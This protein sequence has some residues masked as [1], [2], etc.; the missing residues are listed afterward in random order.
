M[1]AAV[2]VLLVYG[3]SPSGHAA[4]A[5]SLEE[6]FRAEGALVSKVEVSEGHHPRAGRTVAR[7][8]HALLRAFPGLYGA[9]YGSTSARKALRGIRSAYLSA[10]GANRLIAGV[11]REA[12]DLIVCPQAAVAAVFA[13]A[14]ARG[15]LDVPVV[16]VLTDYAAHPFWADPAADFVI[17]PSQDVA[18]LLERL[19]VP[20]DR[21]SVHGI[22]IHP[23]FSSLP[24]RGEA[25]KSLALPPSAPVVLLTGGSQGLGGL[26]AMA[27]A[28]LRA[29]PR[30]S[31][32]AL[33]GAN[34]GLRRSLS[35]LGEAGGRL[36][37]FGPQPPALVAAMLAASDLHLGKPGGLT[38]AESLAAGAPM[39]LATPL[40]GQERA[41]ARHLIEVGAAVM[42]GEPKKAALVCAG[43]LG[44]RPRLAALRAAALAA[45]RPEAAGEIARSLTHAA[46]TGRM[47]RG[48]EVR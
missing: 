43:L 25:R 21:L 11:R 14:R 48:H 26:D 46:Q 23:A 33:C 9:L 47:A 5:S 42:G 7:G 2:R 29:A 20:S 38:A 6:A 15:E 13:Q 40:P 30:A 10:G 1:K 12:P 28:L 34:D 19:G 17:A 8:Y 35:R 4:A 41:N 36:R 18:D 22:P 39:V 44:D 16:A 45:G 32:L 27:Q 37:A 3:Y 31:V 24:S